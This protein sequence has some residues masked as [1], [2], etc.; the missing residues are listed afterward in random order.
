MRGGQDYQKMFA[1][2]NKFRIH[3]QLF[4]VSWYY[5]KRSEIKPCT[6]WI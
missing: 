3:W 1:H 2:K 4:A 5:S 6:N